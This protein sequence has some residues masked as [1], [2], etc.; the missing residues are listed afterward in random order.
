MSED[1]QKQ[2]SL[3]ALDLK[4]ANSSWNKEECFKMA[5]KTLRGR[6]AR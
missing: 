6:L 2:L 3:R 5:E 1:W 4:Q